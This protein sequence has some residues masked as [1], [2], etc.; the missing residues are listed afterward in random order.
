[1]SSSSK[2]GGEDRSVPGLPTSSKILLTQ[3]IAIGRS[4]IGASITK[5]RERKGLLRLLYTEVAQNKIIT[6]YVASELDRPEAT[7]ALAM[8]GRYVS[9]EAWK[10]ARVDLSQN[11][12]SKDFAVL[13]DYYK[14]VLL[15]EE[16]VAIERA[17]KDRDANHET[18]SD[19][20]REAKLLLQALSTLEGQVEKLIRDKV[21]GV[22]ARDTL[23][24]LA[25]KQ[26][27]PNPPNSRPN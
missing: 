14:N 1:M 22:T 6:A 25:E 2:G 13:S 4:I 7:R 18:S 24:E 9:A 3:I 26:Q 20:V 11:I 16:V 12:S 10:A 19:R 21:R 23:A 5:R 17:K 8:R 27:L 15:L